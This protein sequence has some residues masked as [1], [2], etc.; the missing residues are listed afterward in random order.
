MKHD[1]KELQSGM[2]PDTA[3]VY[4]ELPSHEADFGVGP[5][6]VPP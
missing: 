2:E 5:E 4:E 1:L 3:R 6:P